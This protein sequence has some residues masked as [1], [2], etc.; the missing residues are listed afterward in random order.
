MIFFFFVSVLF[1]FF[2]FP[3]PPLEG[4]LWGMKEETR[5]GGGKWNRQKK[6]A[7]RCLNQNEGEKKGTFHS[8]ESR[9]I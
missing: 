3:F 1:L 5:G 8:R 9:K 2:C 4:C 6:N 7:Q